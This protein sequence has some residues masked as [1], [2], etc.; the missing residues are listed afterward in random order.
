MLFAVVK[1][2]G[3]ISLFENNN[4]IKNECSIIDKN[5][6]V[7]RPDRVVIKDNTLHIIDFKTGEPLPKHKKQINEY[8]DIFSSL[9]YPNISKILVYVN[10]TVELVET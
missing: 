8:G 10:D 4:I 1:H 6:K 2:S 3:L 5:G 9:G 7:L